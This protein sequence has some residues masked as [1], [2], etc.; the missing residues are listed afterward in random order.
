[1]GKAD[2]VID[3]HRT[4]AGASRAAGRRRSRNP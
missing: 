3:P 4:R 2:Q 1:M